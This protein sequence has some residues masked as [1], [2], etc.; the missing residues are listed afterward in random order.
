MG[1]W[2][3]VASVALTNP[4]VELE[5]IAAQAE[6]YVP[7]LCDLDFGSIVVFLFHDLFG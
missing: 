6:D 3:K 4:H 1:C 7:D 2:T 5:R